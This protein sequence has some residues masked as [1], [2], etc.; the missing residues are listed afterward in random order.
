MNTEALNPLFSHR[1]IRAY[2]DKAVEQEK[3]D[4]ILRAVQAAPNWVNTQHVSVIIVKD[5][6][7]RAKMAELCGGQKH[8]A[9]APVFLVFCADYYRT[10]LACQK[11][12]QTL[13]EVLN[14][15]DHLIIGGNETGIAFG[16]A[17]IAAELQGLAICP[18]GDARLHALEMI[19]ELNLPKYVFPMIGMCIGYAA[20]DPGIK[21]R[22]PQ[23]AVCFDDRYNQNLDTF[24][25]QYD[26]D[27]A[28]YLKIRPW[29]SRVG[30]W[31]QLVA[32]F[33]KPP[34]KHY[35]QIPAALAKQGFYQS[36]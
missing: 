27:Y 29:N 1:S 4:N 9:Q 32:D 17:T 8:I 24:I 28:D 36:Q 3:L 10:H 14:D 21:P 2:Q 7:R 6:A 16:T 5:P 11:Y 18:I 19:E 35:P 22:L 34:Y 13:D 26:A 20:E 12:G 25:E 23:A 33:Y 31:T 30:N 15:I